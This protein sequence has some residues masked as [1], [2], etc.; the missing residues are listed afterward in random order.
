MPPYFIEIGK[1]NIIARAMILRIFIAE[2]ELVTLDQT[3]HCTVTTISGATF[4][5]QLTAD[6]VVHLR[7][8]LN[9]PVYP[10]A[11][12]D[13]ANARRLQDKFNA[14]TDNGISN[15]W[16]ERIDDN[17]VYQADTGELYNDPN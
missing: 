15:W 10:N 5:I 9:P 16:N 4:T 1:Y 3:Y 6:E 7:N 17:T 14:I 2:V 8:Q 11:N 12:A 13:R